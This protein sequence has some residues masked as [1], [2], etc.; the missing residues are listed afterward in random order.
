MARSHWI[1]GENAG[2]VQ[3][4][5]TLDAAAAKTGS[6]GGTVQASWVIRSRLRRCKR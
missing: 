5:G 2:E 1:A 6:S 4:T 3:V